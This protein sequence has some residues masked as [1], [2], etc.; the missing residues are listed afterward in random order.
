MRGPVEALAR[1]PWAPVLFSLASSSSS[2]LA[3]SCLSWRSFSSR[4][5]ISACFS[6]SRERPSIL[7]A[8]VSSDAMVAMCDNCC[9][10]SWGLRCM[11]H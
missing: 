3:T 7:V 11:L 4:A 9:D 1:R 10:A 8:M 5:A 6:S 2:L